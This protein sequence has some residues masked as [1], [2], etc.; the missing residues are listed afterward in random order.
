MY[1]DYHDMSRCV[2]SEAAV[3]REE[4]KAYLQNVDVRYTKMLSALAVCLEV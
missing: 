3:D 4:T 1:G 2:Q